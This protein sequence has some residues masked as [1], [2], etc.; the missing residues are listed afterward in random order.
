MGVKVLKRWYIALLSA[1]LAFAIAG[2]GTAGAAANSSK[3]KVTLNGKAIVFAQDPVIILSKTYVEFRT[4]FSKL[5]YQIEYTA[6]TKTINAV[7][8]GHKIQMS[9]NG[10]VAFVDGKVVDSKGE[11]KLVKNRTMVG[12]RFVATL[13]GKAVEW[14]AG[15]RTVIIKDKGPTAA[16]TAEVLSIFDK[17]A[18]LEAAGG[19]TGFAELLASDS[20]LDPSEMAVDWTKIKTRTIYTEKIIESYMDKVAVVKVKDETQKVSGEFFPPNRSEARYTLHKDASGQWKIYDIELLSLEIIHPEKLFD[21]AV[22]LPEADKTEIKSLIDTQLKANNEENLDAYLATMTFDSETQKQEAAKQLQ[23][24][25]DQ[26]D[27]VT[28]LDQ[29]APVEYNG[30]DKGS[31]LLSMIAEVKANGT[32]VKVKTILQ[33]EIVKKDGKWLMTSNGNVLSSEE[34]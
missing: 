27:A 21:Q 31:I 12:V 32:T 15:Q 2:S 1:I 29:W 26:I 9:F 14:N 17:M 16:Q 6:K 24:I 7:A 22:E 5:G 4:L 11:M 23:S 10:D 3:I 25:F 8:P 33:N 28:T 34:Q 19:S 18:M 30:S 20:P 13:S